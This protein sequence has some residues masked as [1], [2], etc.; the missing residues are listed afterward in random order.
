M[1]EMARRNVDE[2]FQAVLESSSKRLEEVEQTEEYVDYLNKEISKYISRIMG[3]EGN[4]RDSVQISAFFKICGNLERISDHAVNICEYTKMLES[5][6]IT[7]SALAM[8]E[9]SEMKQVSLEAMDLISNLGGESSGADR[10]EEISSLEQLIDD[11]TRLYRQN[12]I[13]RMQDGV[14]SDEAC[15]LYSELLTDFERIGDHVL[16]IGE[17][18]Q[19]V[20]RAGR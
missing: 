19:N 17:A 1:W 14:C 7:F 15:V 4:Q 10:I 13:Q 2:S 3:H 8:A 6:G 20:R 16:N 12:Q 5:K 18:L 11:K 9:V